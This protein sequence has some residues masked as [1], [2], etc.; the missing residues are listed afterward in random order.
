MNREKWEDIFSVVANL[1]K[2]QGS[3]SQI[4][5]H[6]GIT[7]IVPSGTQ[8][9]VTLSTTESPWLGGPSALGFS[10]TSSPS[11]SSP[12]S[13][14]FQNFSRRSWSLGNTSTRIM[15]RSSIYLMI[16]QNYGRIQIIFGRWMVEQTDRID[17]SWVLDITRT[18][19][20]W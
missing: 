19:A 9:S 5:D 1:L 14:I 2:L 3:T 11:L 20:A 17:K 4:T 6:S 7:L 18:G 15:S 10:C 13:S 12:P 8:L 16:W